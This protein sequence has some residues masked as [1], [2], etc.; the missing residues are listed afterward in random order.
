[1]IIGMKNIYKPRIAHY[2]KLKYKYED[3][4]NNDI[5]SFFLNIQI[6]YKFNLNVWIDTAFFIY[7]FDKLIHTFTQTIA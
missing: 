6:D 2:L 1:M 3:G 4:L 7:F 5:F